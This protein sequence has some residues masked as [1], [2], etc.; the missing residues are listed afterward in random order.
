M[1]SNYFFAVLALSVLYILYRHSGQIPR[2]AAVKYLKNGALVIDVRDAA[3]FESGHLSQAINM[4]LEEVEAR[5]LDSVK[6]KKKV[7]LLHCKT[8]I[9]SRIAKQRLAGMG[10]VNVF[11]LGSYERAFRIVSG[12]S[13]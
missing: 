6:D 8:G 4:P 10:Y 9:R 11:N 12:R 3:E 1:S 5:V 2:K 7:L 13:L